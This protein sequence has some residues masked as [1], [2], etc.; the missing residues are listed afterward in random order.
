MGVSGGTDILIDAAGRWIAR[1]KQN[2]DI[3]FGVL[4]PKNLQHYHRYAPAS[5]P[6]TEFYYGA[7]SHLIYGKDIESNSRGQQGGPMM[8]ALFCLARKRM[9][10]EARVAAGM[11]RPEFEPEYADDGFSE[12]DAAIVLRV[13]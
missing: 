4:P 12:G 2:P 5:A 11:A 6:F 13:F 8:M 1:A 3:V 9:A 7:S 10:E